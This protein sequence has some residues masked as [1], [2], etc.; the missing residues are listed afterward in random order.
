MTPKILGSF[1]LG[2]I[3]VLLLDFLLFIG[4]KINYIDIYHIKVYYNILF[5][6]N[7]SY[8][9]LVICSAIFGYLISGK[10]TFKIFAYIYIFFILISLL[11]FYGPI[12]KKL[13]KMMFEKDNLVFKV[14]NTTFKGDLLYRGRA[15]TYIYRKDINKIVKLKT[16]LTT[17]TNP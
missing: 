10:K 14:G 9:I 15:L 13:G 5:V 1:F 6:D 12:G 3:F 11:S 8:L 16:P 7:Q 2:F 17:Y 4:I